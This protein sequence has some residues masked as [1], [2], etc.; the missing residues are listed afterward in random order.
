MTRPILSDYLGEI[1]RI[2]ATKAG[3]GEISYYAA[4]GGAL[5]AAG[6][7]LRPRVFCVPNLRNRGAGFP[8]MGLFVAGRG[9]APEEWPAGRPP[10]RGVVEVDDVPAEISL[11]SKSSQVRRY[12]GAYGIVLVTNYR[13]FA[14]LG[15][16]ARGQ[17]EQR[18][19]FTFGCDDAGAF[20]ALARSTRWSPGVRQK[21]RRISRARPAAPGAA[22]TPRGRR[23]LSRL[24]RA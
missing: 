8:D 11:K 10:E 23:L 3:T 20:F 18:E 15:L 1:A 21:I 7:R 4:L 16:D 22:R 13:E 14:L 9:L 24:L 6:E 19:H 12:L 17:I 2:R 5:N